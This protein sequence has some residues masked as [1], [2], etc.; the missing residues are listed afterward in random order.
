VV[1]SGVGSAPTEV[2]DAEAPD[3]ETL[4]V[5]IEEFKEEEKGPFENVR[6]FCEDGTVLPPRPYACAEHGGGVQHGTWNERT[7]AMRAAG[8]Q[9]ANVLATL[10]PGRFVGEEADLDLLKQILVERFLIGWD[11]GWI[12]RGARTYRGALQIEDEE[13]GA[14]EIV[15]TMLADPEWHRRARFMLVRETVRLLPLQADEISAAR[16]RQLALNLAEKDTDFTPL[17]AKIHGLPDSGDAAQVREYAESS[18]KG[19]LKE[20]YEE[21]AVAIDALYAATAVD[22]VESL[23]AQIEDPGFARR[24]QDGAAQLLAAE[25][26]AGRL[27]VASRLL[28]LLRGH[29]PK[30]EQPE[31]ALE[32]LE[33]SLAL[34][35]EAYTSGNMV[36]GN[37]SA[38]ARRERLV[39]LDQTGE[40]LYGS[41]FITSRHLAGIKGSL[42]RLDSGE[43][44]SVDDYRAELR[45]LARAP[46]WSG[47]WMAFNFGPTV[48]RFA[49]IEPETHLYPQDRLR[50]SPLL[51]YGAVI[52]DLVRDANGLAGV[53]HD[54]F[55]LRVG[56]GLRA[57]NPGLTRGTLLTVGDESDVVTDGIYILPETTSDLPRVAGILTQGEGSSLSHVQLLARNLGIPNVVVGEEHLPSVRARLGTRVVLAVSPNG[58]VQLV[59][60]SPDWDSVFGAEADAGE[61][62][63]IIRPDLK[64]LDIR[65]TELIQLSGLRAADSG[66]TSGPKGANLGELK[67][68]FGDTVPNGFVIPFGV[69]RKL[70]DDPIES[71]G[72]SVFEWM[73]ERYAA[74]A[75][76]GGDPEEQRHLVTQFLAR[77]RAWIVSA[78][79]RPEFR[80]ALRLQLETSFGADGTYGVFVRS[81]TNVEDL[82]GFTGAGLNLTVPNVVG[83]ENIISAIL[84]VWASPF[85]DRAYGWRQAHMED[86]EYVFP[87]VVVQYSFPAEKSGVMVTT[88]VDS[89]DPSW[90]SVAVNEG[91]G[92]AV[93][94]QAS[95]SL[96]IPRNGGRVQFLAQA[97]APERAVLSPGGGIDHEGASGTASVL[98]KDEIIAL[99]LM[100]RDV[101][102]FPSLQDENGSPIPAD[103]EF[104][105]RDGELALLQIRP[106]VE[107]G[108]AQS[109]A[110]LSR[111]DAGFED[112]GETV[113]ALDAVPAAPDVGEGK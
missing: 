70:L 31:V 73:K 30:I 63:A 4:R 39:L 1:L 97:T 17:R 51:V 3:A 96:L 19:G 88:D 72:P 9:V 43:G 104:A 105:F 40:A 25:D 111:L 98:S 64:K 66:R 90:L 8:Y 77:L 65:S 81:D 82:P 109:S 41:G 26:A 50:G 38:L 55:G 24:L 22:R 79:L 84:Q 36:L 95:E 15:L 71:G 45:Y 16:V 89:G 7:L 32:A 13:A 59:E 37:L 80:E 34:E 18:G 54:L 83:Y 102:R 52:D 5:W 67:H 74:I 99:I 29:F 42:R 76:E 108:R 78:G 91:V 12:F 87:A 14:R 68:H 106:F 48:E 20:Q 10:E 57:L 94:G 61:I 112:R 56:A 46:E 33:T 53:E 75:A 11:D 113:V 47:R 35:N 21:L 100:A 110:Y 85:T 23:A 2:P 103:I 27:A 93:E 49:I 44:P 58:V 28:G 6:W 60:D 92:G 107:S 69:F 101:G 86:P 62:G